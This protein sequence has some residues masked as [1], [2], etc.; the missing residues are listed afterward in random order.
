MPNST[1]TVTALCGE[2]Q[3]EVGMPARS[4]LGAVDRPADLLQRPKQL[5]LG[6]G[7]AS[8]QRGDLAL[9][10]G[11][12]TVIDKTERVRREPRAQPLVGAAQTTLRVVEPP[13]NLDV[14]LKQSRQPRGQL[15]RVG[16]HPRGPFSPT[17]AGTPER[18]LPA[19]PASHTYTR[20]PASRR[21]NITSSR[22]PDSG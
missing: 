14:P 9:A 8:A 7:P 3:L 15:T 18:P 2:F 16:G 13:H 19:D 17:G 11:R 4:A 1:A 10:G 20:P 5:G 6:M 21:T 12:R 22:W